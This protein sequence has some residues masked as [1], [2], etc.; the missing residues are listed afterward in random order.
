MSKN[1]TAATKKREEL[2]ALQRAQAEATRRRR[3]LIVAAG[4][5]ALAL[6]LVGIVIW[7]TT[8][9]EPPP[10]ETTSPT[11]SSQFLPPHLGEEGAWIEVKSDNVSPNAIIFDEHIDY[12]CP[13]CGVAEQMLGATL[14]E[15]A[16]RGDIIWRVHIRN[17]VD[18]MVKNDSSTRAAQAALCA[19]VVGHFSQFHQVVFANQPT[20]GV[21]YTDQQLRVQFPVAAGINGE[22]LTDFQGCYDSGQTVSMV[23][24]MNQVNSDSRTVNGA[25]QDPPGGTPAFFVHSAKVGLLEMVNLNPEKTS[26][27]YVVDPSPDEFLTFLRTVAGPSH[28]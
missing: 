22:N 8:P 18:I 5:V 21:G 12:Q 2:Q 3:I 7:Q 20:E 16:E 17:F 11:W 27:I 15:L 13:Y 4:V 19:D 28:N 24:R 23:Q 10:V 14:R 25:E 26:W 1:T 9:D 6:I